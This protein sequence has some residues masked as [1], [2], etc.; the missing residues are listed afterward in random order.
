MA[1]TVPTL[2]VAAVSVPKPAMFCSMMALISSAQDAIFFLLKCFQVVYS[3]LQF[4]MVVRWCLF[5][6]PS[7]PACG[8]PEKEGRAGTPGVRGPAH[9]GHGTAS[10]GTP[11]CRLASG[12]LDEE[13]VFVALLVPFRPGW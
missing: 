2:A 6:W 11:S 3:L 7:G 9:P 12:E 5:R 4:S 13:H 1:M 10:P 8:G